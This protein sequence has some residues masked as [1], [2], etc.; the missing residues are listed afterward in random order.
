MCVGGKHTLSFFYLLPHL[1]L[2][3]SSS[4]PLLSSTSMFHSSL[5]SLSSLLRDSGSLH[6]DL[7]F[8]NH[9]TGLH[10]LHSFSL[11]CPIKSYLLPRWLCT[12]GKKIKSCVYIWE[13]C[14]FFLQSVL[15]AVE[16]AGAPG[17]PLPADIGSRE[18]KGSAC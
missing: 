3:L 4:F 11:S 13:S 7:F 8:F 17:P 10:S 16:N 15:S 5:P 12:A 14:F 9:H 6:T 18:T 1:L 2:H